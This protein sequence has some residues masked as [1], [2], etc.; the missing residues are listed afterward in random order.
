[1]KKSIFIASF[2][3][4]LVVGWIGSGQLSNNVIAQDDNTQEVPETETSYS[5]NAENNQSEE[6][7]FSVETKVFT[8]KLIDQSIELQGQTIHNKKID[9]KSE[10]SGN[11]DSIEFSRG[12]KVS[13]NAEM[14]T[15][16]LEDR[17]E[18]LL[19]AKKDLER[20]SKELILNEK[21]RDNL[22]RQN[23]ER[24]ELYEIEYASAKQLID[25]GLSS[26][27]KLSLAS[28]NLANAKADKEDIK[29]KFESTLANLEAQISNVKSVLKNIKLDIDKTSIKAPFDGIIS[30]KMVEETEFISLGTPLFTIIDLDP[31]KIEGYLSE[32]D[33]N[34]VSVGTK[35][36]IED[37][38]GIKKN[39]II[40]F[41]SPSA[42]TSTR[43]FEIT[44]EAD[45]KDLSY[46]SGIT[47]KIIIKGSELKAHKIPPSILTLLDDGTVGVKAVDSDNNVTFYPTKTIKDTI[48]GMWVS[49]LPEKVN[50]I[51]SGQEYISIG[52]KIN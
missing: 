14:I 17:N 6:F 27:S 35:A 34:K 13:Q 23:V 25:K 44:I 1:M 36:I 45:N 51:V 31:I 28:F 41:I 9:V 3:L 20:L 52:E 46:K 37:S 8:S 33:I 19:S 30:E 48:D 26:K 16:S 12:D 50:L 24:I 43:T 40:S 7:K 18:K 5:T 15:I 32:F 38:N 4:L 22:L 47:T 11:I 21:N 2:F 42:E 29:I 49:G 39:G 10:T